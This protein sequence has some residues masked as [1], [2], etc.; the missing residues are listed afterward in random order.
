MN[1][2]NPVLAPSF[3][4]PTANNLEQFI[5][6]YLAAL[7]VRN[8]SPQTIESQTKQLRYFCRFCGKQKIFQINAVTREAVGIY[9]TRLYNYRKKVKIGCTTADY[10]LGLHLF[11]RYRRFGFGGFIFCFVV[12]I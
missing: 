10:S 9:Q 5:S 11:S 4:T 8:Y 2:T 1:V 3:Q 7:T 12:K 6:E